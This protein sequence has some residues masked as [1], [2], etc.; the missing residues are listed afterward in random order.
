M[1]LAYRSAKSLDLNI[2]RTIPR[3]EN[4]EAVAQQTPGAAK[5]DSAIK[6][7]S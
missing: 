1:I 6:S 2:E 4:R 3:L 5:K 7:G